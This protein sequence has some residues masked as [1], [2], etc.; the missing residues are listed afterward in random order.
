MGRTGD[1]MRDVICGR[2]NEET[3]ETDRRTELLSQAERWAHACPACGA[4]PGSPCNTTVYAVAKAGYVCDAR[5]V[6]AFPNH[7]SAAAAARQER[8]P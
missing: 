1:P 4:V 8:K 5:P 3:T 2:C 6:D 7:W